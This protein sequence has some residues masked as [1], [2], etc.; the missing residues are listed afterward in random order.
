MMADKVCP[1]CR[2]PDIKPF[3]TV[4]A[5]EY[6]RCP[7]CRAVFLLPAQRLPLEE[8]RRRY[9]LHRN[10]PDDPDYRRFLTRLAA[11]LLARLDERGREGLDYGCGPGPA[12]AAIFREAGHRVCLY[13]PQF[14]PDTSV[15]DATYDFITCTEVFEHFHHPADEL[16]R[17]R[18]LLRP[19]GWLAVM[20]C[21][22]TEDA[23]FADWHYRSDPTHVVF[24]R[25]ETF[26][27]LADSWGWECHI[28]AKDV[29]LLRKP[30]NP[31][32]PPG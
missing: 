17:L 2:E 20:T 12:L 14:Y 27:Y 16:D 32:S 21:F 3:I 30:V 25:E 7:S 22:Q 18:C 4:G 1:V 9:R 31:I 28:P 13:D 11:P 10:H 26:R 23:A 19:G 5:S 8:E 6:L 15:L 29:A 24:Y